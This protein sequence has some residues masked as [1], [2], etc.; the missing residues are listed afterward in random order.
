MRIAIKVGTSTLAFDTYR[1]NIRRVEALCKVLSDVKNMGHDVILVTSG[2]IAMGSGKLRLPSRPTDI[3]TKQA[4]AAVGQCELMYVYDELFSRYNHIVGQVLLTGSDVNDSE[5]RQHFCDT[6]NR[7][8][9]MGVIPIINENDTV[10]TE[11]IR[12]GDNDTLAAV[13]AVNV[14]ADLLIIL[15]DID[16]LYDADPKKVAGAKLIPHVPQVTE[17]IEAL[18]GQHQSTLGTGGMVTKLNAA[19]MCIAGGVEMIIAN[20]GDPNCLYD[21]LEGKPV[22][23]VFGEKKL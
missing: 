11:E 17:A 16:G 12:F 3:P 14:K 18:A 15:S 23:T 7:L 1:I 9:E 6:M 10:T 19:K 4:A 5:R 8:M 13:V 2:A 20:G 22:G 21:I